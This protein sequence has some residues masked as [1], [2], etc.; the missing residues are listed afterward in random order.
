MKPGPSLPGPS[1]LAN[2][3]SVAT[4]SKITQGREL[5]CVKIS[6]RLVNLSQ[7]T[8]AC[9]ALAG[10]AAVQTTGAG[11]QDIVSGG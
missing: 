1:L 11:H 5:T 7:G 9:L 3:H 6:E 8:G 2:H 10:E 4:D